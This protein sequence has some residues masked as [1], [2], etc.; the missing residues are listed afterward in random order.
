M[1]RLTA[2]LDANILYPAP[3]RDIF[4]QLAVDDVFRAKW[5]RDIHRE[6]IAALLRNEPHRER[7][8]LERTRDFMNQ[9]TRDCLVTGYETL[10]SS[11]ELPD[12]QD[13]H[14]LAA[15][16]VGR[17]DVIVTFNLRDFPETA[18]TP[19]EIEVQ[20]PDAFLSS[21]LDLMPESFRDAVRKIRARLVAPSLSVQDYLAILAGQGL[22]ATAAE[23]SRSSALL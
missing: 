21:H 9:A 3:T 5:T 23:L 4:L 20:H 13:R 10:I 7:A 17:C 6:W 12:P 11:L 19:F 14:V 8:A 15:A 22:V 16:I 2:L 18:V 1:T